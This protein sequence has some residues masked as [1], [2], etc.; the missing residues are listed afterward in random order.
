[1]DYEKKVA[2]ALEEL[3]QCDRY[4]TEP[5]KTIL[6]LF[7]ELEE[8]DYVIKQRLR[9]YLEYFRCK[10][11]DHNVC[12]RILKWLDKQESTNIIPI[13]DG[14][15][16]YIKDRK[17]YI[18]SYTKTTPTDKIEPKF[19]TGDTMR[20]LEEARD[21]FTSGMPMVVSIDDEYYHCTNES[22]AIKDQDN[23]EYPPINRKEGE[24]KPKFKIGDWVIINNDEID[25]DSIQFNDL[26]LN[27]PLLIVDFDVDGQLYEMEDVNG[28]RDYPRMKYIDNLY[29]LWTLE[30]AKDGDVL[31]HSK[32]TSD[33]FD[34]IFIYN[35]T[36][37]LQA[38]GYYS[39][40]K[41]GAFVKDRSHYCPWNMDEVIIPATKKQRDFLRSKLEEIHFEWDDKNKVFFH[42]D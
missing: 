9:K 29:H 8:S 41:D 38:Y 23:Y 27:S 36:S 18:E 1:M 3:K 16:A 30:D 22:I 19:Q 25:L 20:T 28:N 2:E 33:D 15:H 21:G 5:A 6:K 4:D 40:K 17:V 32:H 39:K 7:P 31:M 10:G 13:P 12:D 11:V 42:I 34:Y 14:C 35:K 24:I 26:D 37:L